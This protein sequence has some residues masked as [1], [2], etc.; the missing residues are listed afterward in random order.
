MS[1]KMFSFLAAVVCAAGVSMS[2]CRAEAGPSRVET[3]LKNGWRFH[4]GEA[5]G[6]FVPGYDDS[7]WENVSVPHDWAITGPFSI[8]ND[9]QNVQIV[10]NMETK[11]SLKTGR[12]GGLPY[13]GVGWYRTEF[14]V[15]D[16]M[17]AELLFDG[18]MSEAR[19]Y[20]NGHEVCFWPYGYSPFHCDVTPYLNKSGSNVLAVRLENLPFSSRW[21]PGAGLYRNVHLVCT[22]AKAHIPVW[23]TFVSTP[24]VHKDM[25]SVSLAISLQSDK[26]NI[27]IEYYTD[28]ISPE[29]EKVAS[30]RSVA[31]YH[32]GDSHVQKFLVKEPKLWSPEHPY[33]YKA[34]TRVL[35]DGVVTDEY[36][37]SFGIRSIE[38]IPEKG[39]YLNGEH[40]KFKGV[41]NHH[42]LGPLGAAVSV[43]ALRHQLTMLKDM[44]CDAVRTSHNTPAPELVSLCDEMGL[45]MMVEPFDEWDDA[46]CQNGYHR[47]FDE[48]AERDMISMLHAFRNSPSVIMW[49]IGN[50]VPSQCT[51]DGYK[52]AAF[53]QSICHRE[54]P[55]RPVTCGMDQVNCVLS[56]GFAAQLDIPGINY[57]TFRYKDCYE[58]L[59]QGLV[60]GS[61]TAS[62]V[63]SR[64]TYHFP[65]EKAFSV[66]HEDHQS[67]GY[68]MEACNWSNI[69]DVDLALAED[70]PWTLGQFVWTGFD[71]LGEPS[72]YDTDAWPN[73]SS[74]FGIIDLASIPKD[75]YWLYRSVWNTESPTLHIVPHWTWPGREGKVTPVYVYTSWPEAELFVNGV[76][77][78]RRSKLPPSAPCEG[79]QDEALES[80]YRLMWNDVV[81]QKGEIRVVAYDAKG[82]VAASESVRTAGKPYALRLECDRNSIARDGEDLAYVTVS[83][84]DKDGNTVPTDTREVLASV[85]GA[86]EFRAIA[87]G[88]PCSLEMF[89]YPH[90]HLFAGKLTV[91]VRSK[92]NADGPILLKV[93]AKGLRS[94]EMEL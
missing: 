11:A 3:C 34:L 87:N 47:Y 75:R 58:Q 18:A 20:V 82:N 29:G 89:H 91:I 85:S 36:E 61:E 84:T 55:T 2:F 81:Y 40:R 74:M 67:S 76:S 28:I 42:D 45:M 53:L 5:D 64:G 21:Y 69:P 59:P 41:C 63:S 38:F 35:V 94:A 51:A 86:G 32:N 92:A 79:L 33:L 83:V 27:D 73:H 26:E 14:S 24:S 70:Y 8:E 19:V 6:A 68:D 17:T 13:V 48:W 77:Q 9:L 71:Y 4:R 50:E 37:T 44:G 23:G 56:N 80:R 39:F 10:Q 7:G 43:P 25:A 90:M 60:L 52:T 62:T 31:L 88:D 30:R 22:S 15:P 12:T 1:N 65:V 57:R 93:N 16:G 72:P 46:K 49:S 54:D 66:K 78:G